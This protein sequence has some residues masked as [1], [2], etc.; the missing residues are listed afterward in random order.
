MSYTLAWI[1]KCLKL[2]PSISLIDD[3]AAATQPLEWPGWNF[4]PLRA[5][6]NVQYTKLK[7]QNYS[8]SVFDIR[9]I[10]HFC[11]FF[12]TVE[13]RCY[14]TLLKTKETINIDQ[15][16][17][18]SPIPSNSNPRLLQ[19][20]DAFLCFH[21]DSADRFATDC[22]W[23]LDSHQWVWARHRGSTTWATAGTKNASHRDIQ[24]TEILPTLWICIIDLFGLKDF[25]DFHWFSFSM[26]FSIFPYL[27]LVGESDK[28]T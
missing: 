25:N 26:I 18:D 16:L 21:P 14:R 20:P 5:Q 28:R 24:R 22:P 7:E 27:R 15:L 12:F 13:K 9:A 8:Y 1:L 19:F 4:P 23:H 17:I 2:Y 11:A 6:S 10:W 3:S